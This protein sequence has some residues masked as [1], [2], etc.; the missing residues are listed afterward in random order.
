MAKEV[1][2]SDLKGLSDRELWDQISQ[3]A[4]RIASNTPQD[5]DS[6]DDPE[7][8]QWEAARLAHAVLEAKGRSSF[9]EGL[10]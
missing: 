8:W 4:N 7:E 5:S 6:W 3:D 10:R 2:L 1:T 9:L